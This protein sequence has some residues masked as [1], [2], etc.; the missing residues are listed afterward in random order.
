[1]CFCS[2]VFIKSFSI[3]FYFYFFC[4]VITFFEDFCTMANVFQWCIMT[5]KCCERA[6]FAFLLAFFIEYFQF[7]FIYCLF[8]CWRDFFHEFLQYFD[9]DKMIFFDFTKMQH[10]NWLIKIIRKNF[11]CDNFIQMRIE[12]TLIAKIKKRNVLKSSMRRKTNT[13]I[14]KQMFQKKSFFSKSKTSSIS[15]RRH[16]CHWAPHQ[17]Q[18]KTVFYVH[19]KKIN[20]FSMCEIF[21]LKYFQWRDAQKLYWHQ[22]NLSSN[23]IIDLSC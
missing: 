6:F 3:Q 4:S 5:D 23:L 8:L 11:K 21:K 9:I 1:M 13:L 7:I 19:L 10:H 12:L 22:I 16:D 2:H 18:Q 17:L 15:F 14:L 20:R